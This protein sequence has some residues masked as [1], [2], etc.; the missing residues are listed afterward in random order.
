MISQRTKT[1]GQLPRAL[2]MDRPEPWPSRHLRKA[3]TQAAKRVI[4]LLVSSI[5]LLVFIP[6]FVLIGLLIKLDSA[7]PVFY[8][9]KRIGKDGKP[10]GMY[11]FRTMRDVPVDSGPRITAR[12]DPRIT[13]LGHIL[14]DTKL[15]ELPQIINVLKGEMSLVGPRPEDPQYVA[16]Y[17]PEQRHVLSVTPGITSIASIVYCNEESILNRDNWEKTYVHVIMPDKLRL[18]MQYVNNHSLW[19]DLDILLRT[20]KALF[21]HVAQAS[22]EIEDF[23]FGPVQRFVR[24]YLS[25]FSLDLILGLLSILTVKLLWGRT[26][27]SVDMDWPHWIIFI[28][29]TAFAFALMNQLCGLQHS[30][31]DVASSHEVIDIFL[32]AALSTIMLL[33]VNGLWCGFLSR[34]LPFGMILSGGF[35]AF[36]AFSVARYRSRLVTGILGRWRNKKGEGHDQ[37]KTRLLI[38]GAGPAGQIFARQVQNRQDG[39]QYQVV[40]FVDDDLAKQRMYIQGVP[41]LGNYQ[42]IPTLVAQHNIDV[43]AVAIHDLESPCSPDLLEPLPEHTGSGGSQS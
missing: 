9:G 32:A 13:R 18:D 3:A 37:K 33:I 11:K 38:V 25:W 29:G 28:I 5:G 1:M 2:Y 4:D 7:G 41:V 30:M 43:I 20:A 14:R 27:V 19:V 39:Q 40:G 8:R 31:W 22:P 15:N 23:M 21:P 34:G 35:L 6:L 36:S 17:T 24:R 16:L 42:A 26:S 12:G 10:F